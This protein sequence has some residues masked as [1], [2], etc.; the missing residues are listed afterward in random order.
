[1]SRRSASLYRYSQVLESF[2][3]LESQ[4]QT[5]GVLELADWHQWNGSYRLAS[6]YY[7]SVVKQLLNSGEERLLQVWFGEPVELP[8]NGAFWQP[9]LK[10]KNEVPVIATATFDVTSR[11]RAKNIS[12]TTQ[13]KEDK[14][15]AIKFR[16]ELGETRF[17]P[18]FHNAEAVPSLT[19][20]RDYELYK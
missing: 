7:A 1:M 10:E 3:A 19:L 15:R 13:R 14:G 5:R 16:R 11:G 6:K 8:D 4:W 18:R 2:I 17:R 12:V 20:Q 9:P